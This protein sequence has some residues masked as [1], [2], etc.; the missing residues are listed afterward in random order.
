MVF[1]PSCCCCCV[2]AFHCPSFVVAFHPLG[3]EFEIHY[4]SFV[5]VAFHPSCCCVFAFH[6]PSSAVAYRHPSYGYCWLA[7][8][9][10]AASP[11]FA[12]ATSFAASFVDSF[13]VELIVV[14]FHSYPSYSLTL[15]AEKE[16][17][18]TNSKYRRCSPSVVLLTRMVP[19]RTCWQTS[20]LSLLSLLL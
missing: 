20:P 5:V 17:W 8:S 9:A 18:R 6:Y 3:C 10:F 1:H 12:V 4:P 13:V 15:K 7:V 19:R 11:S 2:C 14:T 16:Q